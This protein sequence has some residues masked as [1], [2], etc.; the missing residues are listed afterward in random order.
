M[1]VS[2]RHRM[3][4][5][6]LEWPVHA[7]GWLLYR[8]P[9]GLKWFLS[10]T[11]GAFWFRVL[12]FRRRVVL[13]NLAVVFPR[14]SQESMGAFRKRLETLAQKNLAHMVMNLL[15]SFERSHWTSE[16]LAKRVLV[17]GAEHL[18]QSSGFFFLT[19]H[20]GNWELVSRVGVLLGLPLA[21]VTRFLRSAWANAVWVRVRERY[22]LELLQESG[23]GLQMIRAIRDKKA[24]GFMMD[25]HTGE[26]HGLKTR[27]LGLEAWS[28]KGLAILSLRLKCPVVPAFF[29]REEHS[30]HHVLTV[31]KPIQMPQEQVVVAGALE[32][33]LSQDQL[34]HHIEICNR[35][36]EEQIR[37]HPEQ[38][39]WMHKRFK[40]WLNYKGALPWE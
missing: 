13:H 5:L 27:F 6:V 26:P 33:T 34:L 17:Q 15:E 7:L 14:Q 1:N 37:K 21:I 25:Q 16:D 19:A 10:L 23:S 29:V 22:G 30:G 28:P 2:K 40:T 3:F 38:Y 11:L 35:I 20:L 8:A 4:A 32:K 18:R 31:L 24:V 36:Q 39:L 12:R 9:F